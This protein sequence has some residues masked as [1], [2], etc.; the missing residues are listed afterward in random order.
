MTPYYADDAVTLYHGDCR[1]VIP[2]L[3]YVDH[4]LTDPPYGD[5]THTGARTNAGQAD[6]NQRPA[7]ALIGDA[8]SSVDADQIRDVL[9]LVRL[10]RWCVM[11]IDWQ[12]MLPLKQYPPIGWRFVRMGAW[13]KPNGAPQFTGDRP[14]QGFEAVA[15]LHAGITGKMRWN[16][17]GLP[18]V[19]NHQRVISGHPAGKP[20]LLLLDWVCMFTDP[21]DVVL[22]PF[23][24]SGTT[25]AAAKRLGR[26][27]IGIEIDEPYCERIARRLS[28]GALPLDYTCQ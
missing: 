20:E 26:K 18:A 7:A 2:T 22:D 14:A 24:G 1:E 10:R 25:L 5:D 6:L 17:G 4:V 8:W 11:S 13:V 16:G 9:N 12:H 23:A 27:A 21:G 19:W 15:I 28:Q 3:G